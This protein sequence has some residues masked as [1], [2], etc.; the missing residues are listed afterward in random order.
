M[1]SA[2]NLDNL[3]R[4][5]L[6][7]SDGALRRGRDY[8]RGRLVNISDQVEQNYIGY[9][10][11][12]DIYTVS[13]DVSSRRFSCTCPASKPCK[14]IVAFC[15][16]VSEQIKENSVGIPSDPG[17]A[18]VSSGSENSQPFLELSWI[19]NEKKEA[20]RPDQRLLHRPG[21]LDQELVPE[22]SEVWRDL[23]KRYSFPFEVPL[24]EAVRWQKIRPTIE[25]RDL[26]GRRIDYAG[27]EEA[28]LYLREFSNRL[29][30]RRIPVPYLE[31]ENK[32]HWLR[33]D[34]S[35][36][37]EPGGA[38]RIRR[39]WIV[40]YPEWGVTVKS[41]MYRALSAEGVVSQKRAL[42]KAS[43][44]GL[45]IFENVYGFGPTLRI[46]LDYDIDTDIWL[47]GEMDLVYAKSGKDM[48]LEDLERQPDLEVHRP[49]YRSGADLASVRIP[50]EEIDAEPGYAMSEEGHL[51]RS[52]LTGLK[53]FRKQYAK[54]LEALGGQEPD[55]DGYFALEGDGLHEFL[56]NALP[57]LIQQ[58]IRVE[59]DRELAR[60][61]RPAP[62]ARFRIDT[63]SGIDWFSGEL[64]IIGISEEEKEKLFRAYRENQSFARLSNGQWVHLRSSK[65][66]RKLEALSELGLKPDSDI[67]LRKGH[68]IALDNELGEGLQVHQ[69]QQELLRSSERTVPSI[70]SPGLKANPR[71]YQVEGARYLGNLYRLGVGGI[72]GDE[73]GLG[74][75]LQAL[76]F[77]Q[78]LQR[79]RSQHP[80]PVLVVAPVSAVSVWHSE[81]GKFCPDLPVTVWHGPERKG[82]LPD[83]GILITTYSLLHRDLKRLQEKEYS[84]I[85]LDEAQNVRNA[86]TKAARA[87]RELMARSVFC[88]TGTPLENRLLDY[89]ALMDLSVPG[90]LGTSQSFKRRF[91][92]NPDRIQRL[93][94]IT[95]PFI[96]R[97]TKDQV[98]AELPEK[99]EIAIPVSMNKEQAS[100]YE[101]VRQEARRYLE[102]AGKDYLMRMLPYLMQLRRIACHPFLGKKD[103]DFSD[104]GK[105]EYLHELLR[106]IRDGE[107][108]AL[109]FSQFTDV[110][111]VAA[112]VADSLAMEYFRIDGSTSQ[113]SRQRQ[114]E[115]FQAG[116][117]SVFLISLKAGGTAL[118]L[119]RADRVIHMDPWWNPAAEAQA[120]D[121]AHRIGQKNHIFIYKLFSRGTVEERVLE[122]QAKKKRLFDSLFDGRST[123]APE[124]TR[125]ELLDIL[126]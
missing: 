11:G 49:V 1:D 86:G 72:L 37:I 73:M 13:V 126:Q 119:H 69:R 7:A 96:L 121:R 97:R 47:H 4:I 103:C 124:I 67:Q 43:V 48:E 23:M 51:V 106:E 76:M 9:A 44:G 38:R 41:L 26:N 52:S 27:T 85:F 45:E 64:E 59:F 28:R 42:K 34:Q 111:D 120:T 8:F 98:A 53:R 115:Q 24:S 12:T 3:Q 113:K 54:A 2:S 39:Y 17:K 89:W 78:A 77:I 110:L 100:I 5:I 16:L 92:G 65:L 116:K 14:H 50:F 84:C 102:E 56:V 68:L 15:L 21:S 104:S 18:S 46:T 90:L 87:L 62:K 29:D 58:G 91:D 108:A 112:M 80:G 66:F 30:A 117:R 19:L 6:R 71:S 107:S 82:E 31:I 10:R 88:L 22:H 122:L 60:L 57:G 32:E 101:S 61:F 35:V 123:R 63:S 118:T 94:E 55:A 105:F 81:A 70:P 20:I 25:I 99:T 40:D 93:R 36:V 74:K 125:Q 109:I 33:P 75:T 95:A 79:S 83:R 114:V